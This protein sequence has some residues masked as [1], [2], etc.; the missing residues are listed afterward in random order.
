L[1]KYYPNNTGIN[2]KNKAIYIVLL[3][4]PRIKRAGLELTGITSSRATDIKTKLDIEYIRLIDFLMIFYKF[5]INFF[6]L[7]HEHKLRL[8]PLQQTRVLDI[9]ENNFN[10]LGI[11]AENDEDE[12]IDKLD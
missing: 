10:D 12:D 6:S 4:D 5:F 11:Y 9:Y 2:T 8:L 7:K 3:L 1:R